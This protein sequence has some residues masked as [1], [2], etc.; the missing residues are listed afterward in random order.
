MTVGEPPL[1]DRRG[2]GRL[3]QGLVGY[4]LVALAVALLWVGA[5]A[6]L[7]G[8]ITGL[9]DEVQAMVPRLTSTAELTAQAL[10]EGASTAG[11]FRTTLDQSAAA[12]SSS[13]ATITVVRGDLSA[14]EAQLRSVSI[15]GARPLSSPADAVGRIATSMDGL[16]TKLSLIADSL[17][18]G[19][20]ALA[21]NATALGELGE[22]TDQLAETLALADVQRAFDDIQLTLALILVLCAAFAFMPA[23]GALWLGLW[24]RRQL[25]RSRP[26]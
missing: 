9:R 25:Q 12:L 14:F 5:L 20:D 18:V 15:L 21:A 24:L 17:R 6:G 8:R 10:R 4:G 26:A 3:S 19:Q 11:S 22:R 1:L 23:I 7:N 13:A 2:W 16:D